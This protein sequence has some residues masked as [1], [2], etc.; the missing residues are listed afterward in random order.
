MTWRDDDGAGKCCV[1]NL[2]LVYLG[3]GKE[4]II[5]IRKLTKFVLQKLA[6]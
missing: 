6:T 2:K 1:V 5:E 4:D 3:Y